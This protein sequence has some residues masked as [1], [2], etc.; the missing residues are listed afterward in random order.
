MIGKLVFLYSFNGGDLAYPFEPVPVTASP[1]LETIS[2]DPYV[3]VLRSLAGTGIVDQ[4][5]VIVKTRED[6][7][8]FAGF[9]VH[10]DS[11]KVE[12]VFPPN[13]AAA[14]EF[15]GPL[16]SDDVVWTRG[17][18]PFWSKELEKL[19]QVRKILYNTARLL[20]DV[21]I[22]DLVFAEEDTPFQQIKK[23]PFRFH[24]TKSCNE[25]VF[26]PT[27]DDKVYDFITAGYVLERKGQLKVIK[28]AAKLLGR[29]NLVF[30]GNIRDE[31]YH[32]E[33]VSVAANL[34]VCV[35]F[36]GHVDRSELA[37]LYSRSRV[38]VLA[39]WG[40]HAPRVLLEAA[41]C[42]VPSVVTDRVG[43]AKNHI[44]PKTGVVCKERR[45]A[46]TMKKVHDR[47]ES[48][49]REGYMESFSS[50]RALDLVVAAFRAKGWA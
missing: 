2:S 15:V 25:S 14:W 18:S 43:G 26:A 39:S 5:F 38:N 28:A 3:N 40:E 37:T 19:P 12:I 13:M 1:A 35:E 42:D 6:S 49:P 27:G 41:C 31:A 46:K 23:H 30:P 11:L 4:V 32:R 47:W 20:A 17:T 33:C 10:K 24:F 29:V 9:G 34:D 48:S 44:T 45:L 16:D 21:S 36:P 8:R 22:Y 50:Q 7:V